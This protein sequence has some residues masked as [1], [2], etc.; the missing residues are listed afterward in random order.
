MNTSEILQRLQDGIIHYKDGALRVSCGTLYLRDIPVLEL[1]H[2][3]V[4]FH[5]AAF[6]MQALIVQRAVFNLMQ[7]RG[8][9]SQEEIFPTFQVQELGGYIISRCDPKS[10]PMA[11]SVCYNTR[12]LL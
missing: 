6:S 12:E 11:V 2:H 4:E 9:I 8:M 7:E 1:R 10:E 5:S 3:E